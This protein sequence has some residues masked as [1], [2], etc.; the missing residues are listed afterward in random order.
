MRCEEKLADALMDVMQRVEEVRETGVAL[1][2]NA[3]IEEFSRFLVEKEEAGVEGPQGAHV[4]DGADGEG[5]G[6][7]HSGKVLFVLFF[8]MGEYSK[9][10]SVNQAIFTSLG[11]A[12]HR[13]SVQFYGAERPDLEASQRDSSP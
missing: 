9:H 13:K 5:K 8:L 3:L 10:I 1:V 6:R 7:V 2:R 12:R 11:K 4:H